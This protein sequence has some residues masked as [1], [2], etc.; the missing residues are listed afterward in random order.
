V[1]DPVDRER[2]YAIDNIEIRNSL[3]GGLQ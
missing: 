3:P 2:W 1:G